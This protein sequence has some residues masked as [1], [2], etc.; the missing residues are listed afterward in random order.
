MNIP[1]NVVFHSSNVKA[2]QFVAAIA[3]IVELKTVAFILVKD[4]TDNSVVD[5]ISGDPDIFV[6]TPGE[7]PSAVAKRQFGTYFKSSQYSFTIFHQA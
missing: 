3:E 4:K 1:S 7:K 6:N 2:S 5:F